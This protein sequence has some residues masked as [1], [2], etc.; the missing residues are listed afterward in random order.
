ML[1][2]IEEMELE[3]EDEEEAPTEEPE[4]SRVERA[5][6]DAK[7]ETLIDEFLKWAAK[8]KLDP[9]DSWN[10][11]PRFLRETKGF[12]KTEASDPSGYYFGFGRPRIVTEKVKSLRDSIRKAVDSLDVKL[13]DNMVPDCVGWA[14]GLGLKTIRQADV[15]VFLAEKGVRVGPVA[16]RALWAKASLQ[17]R[18]AM[19][20][21]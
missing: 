18:V 17:L 15:E 2:E 9:H 16:V 12:P 8:S 6:V 11:L 4:P 13:A 19:G 3:S 20:R 14:S 21:K 5:L 7:D 10:L 1:G